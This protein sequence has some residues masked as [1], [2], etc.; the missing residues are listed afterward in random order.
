MTG[1]TMFTTL[2]ASRIW[3][4]FGW[5][6]LHSLWQAALILIAV[7]AVRRLAGPS[8]PQLAYAAGLSGMLAI[9]FA[10]I[11]TIVWQ[12][13]T[14]GSADIV[15]KTTQSGLATLGDAVAS[16]GATI[17]GAATRFDAGVLIPGVGVM[18][19]IGFFVLVFQCMYAWARTRVLATIGLSDPEPE[20]ATRF[21]DLVRRSGLGSR[22]RLHVSALVKAPLTLGTLKPVVLVPAGFLTGFPP[23][24]VE[25]ILLHELA[26]IRR[27]DFLLG[28]VQ[29]AIRTT[30]YF[31]P[32]IRILSRW[33]DTDR[34]QACD[35]FA[36]RQT[37]RPADLAKGL[38]RLRLEL[39]PA[40]ALTPD[41]AM[42]AQ[43]R[44]GLVDR[45]ERLMGRP[46]Q[47][48]REGLPAAIM[49]AGLITTAILAST[50]FAAQSWA[51][52]HP[53]DGTKPLVLPDTTIGLD[54]HP[55]AP[56]P[57]VVF[58]RPEAPIPP[59]PTFDETSAEDFEARMEEWGETM[60][61]WG[62]AFAQNF[63]DDFEERMEAW[64]EDME[65]WGEAMGEWGESLETR[66][67]MIEHLGDMSDAELR[68]LGL[69][70]KDV[71]TYAEGFGLDVADEVVGKIL[72][73]FI[74]K[75]AQAEITQERDALDKDAIKRVEKAMARHHAN[76]KAEAARDRM[77][78]KR[79]QA[80][81]ERDRL[82]AE[83]DKIHA[84]RDAKHAERERLRA[85]RDAHRAADRA[86]RKKSLI[87]AQSLTNV[88][89]A[90]LRE[91]G[92]I[93][94]DADGFVFKSSPR[95]TKIDGHK[96]PDDVH[97]R[98]R[99]MLDSQNI[100]ASADVGIERDHNRI[101]MEIRENG[102]STRI[103]MTD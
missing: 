30:L 28:L 90:Q 48:R 52:P 103:S 12:V 75:E 1:D 66:G 17:D 19:C 92:L 58:I 36:V 95:W 32:A 102:N 46:A 20:W 100:K 84:E 38:A 44:G 34:E 8:R 101:E 76:N 67:D 71:D 16:G 86:E 5:A 6:V 11:G 91:D 99:D 56:A 78:A 97:A 53:G 21:S 33:I 29:T 15:M 60:E 79:D 55:V 94:P 31:N 7:A 25:A 96:Q 26:H 3:D 83:R 93:A 64:G 14:A 43:G 73:G 77:R 40:P 49:A 74:G 39:A 68:G 82:L 45:L 10:F 22:V 47:V 27:H 98:Y 37:G 51:H 81:A 61:A 87:K 80:Y 18:W 85:E 70:R 9:F 62:E 2:S 24:Q 59:V 4:A 41:L 54:G 50:G 23:A 63:S 72:P 88:L 42:A 65:I 89:E 57:P 69:T 13:S 35:D